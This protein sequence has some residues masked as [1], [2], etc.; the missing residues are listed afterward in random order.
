MTGDLRFHAFGDNR[1]NLVFRAH[2]GA[3]NCFDIS[4][5]KNLLVSGGADW[6]LITWRF[7]HGELIKVFSSHSAA[8]VE[9]KLEE[10]VE[11]NRAYASQ[12]KYTCLL[13]HTHVIKV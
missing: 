9:L 12:G 5:R 4:E 10:V 2:T 6:K 8:V 1:A 13:L 11:T 7:A 3:V